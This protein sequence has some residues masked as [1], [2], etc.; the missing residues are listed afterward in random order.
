MHAPSG[1]GSSV[2]GVSR[3]SGVTTVSDAR[4]E[5]AISTPCV[6]AWRR[7][8]WVVVGLCADMEGKGRDVGECTNIVV[9]HRDVQWASSLR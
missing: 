9:R 3:Y 2:G 6:S 1:V 8:P 7:Y 5:M 4:Y